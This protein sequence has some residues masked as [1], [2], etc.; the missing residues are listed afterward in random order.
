MDWKKTF[1]KTRETEFVSRKLFKIFF[2][3]HLCVCRHSHKSQKKGSGSL[4]LSL[5]DIVSF[6][7][8]VLGTEHWSLERFQKA[9]VVV[10]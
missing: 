3:M 8:W 5:Q 2:I 7:V 4:E 1:I 6:P 9:H 10:C